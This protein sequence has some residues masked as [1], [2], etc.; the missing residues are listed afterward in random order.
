MSNSISF[1]S[2]HPILKWTLIIIIG[3]VVLSY[4]WLLSRMR[5]PYHNYT[6]DFLIPDPSSNPTPSILEVGVA[7]RD[8]TPVLELFDPW[9]DVNNNGK[10]DPGV[11]RFEDRNKNGRFDGIWIAGFGT[12][13]P[14]KGIHDPQWVRAIALRNNGVT[15]VMATF[16]A[17]GIYHNDFITIRKMVDPTLKIDHILFSSTHCHEVIDTMKIWSFWR[18]IKGLDIPI[19]GFNEE[20][21]KFI[22]RMA[23]EAIEE[24]VRNLQPADMY[25]TQVQ[26]GPEGFVEDTRKPIVMDLN[27]YLF[28]FTKHNTDE[29][30]GTLVC[31]GNHPE[32]LG[33]DNNYL[34]SD[35]PHY[36][37]EGLEKGVPEPNGAPGF[38]GI[39]L[40]FQ[41]MLGGLMTQLHVEVPD[42]AGRATY[43]EDSFEKA[44]ALGYNVAKVA[45]EALRSPNV[46]KNEN[47]LIAVA[48]KTFLAPMEGHFKYAIML[49][50]IHEGYY[51]GGRAKSEVNAVRIGDVF[52]LTVPGELYPEVVQ[53]NIEALPG[54]D[55]N[56]TA[57]VESPPLR[58]EMEKEARM[59]FVIGLANDEIGYIIPKSQWDVKPPFVYGNKQYGEINSGGPD[60]APTYHKTALELIQRLNSAYPLKTKKRVSN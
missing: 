8:I 7:K 19:F 51:R 22:Q 49:G 46:W 30:I 50:L 12:N 26:V 10:F 1:F 60:V 16:D 40:Y 36:L 41:G 17:I 52:I 25:C 48:G 54:N 53:G 32:T 21:M 15:L 37:R 59:A 56:L 14:A 3:I 4:L 45:I 20:H 29:T 47:P 31:W 58:F 6:L 24:A 11:D 18:R 35:F 13:R 23:K 34:T 42:R 9:E 43:K 44:E 57:P 2:R 5:G 55:F 27:M 38:G 28:K 39:C 33:S